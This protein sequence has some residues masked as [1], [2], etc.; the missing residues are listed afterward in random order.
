MNIIVRPMGANLTR[1][2]EILGRMD[3]YCVVSCGG[4]R[5]MT[6]V[7]QDGS[8]NPSWGSA[9]NFQAQAPVLAI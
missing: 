6:E 5:Q 2:T 8:K 7:C 4:Q 3:P 1:D 9:L